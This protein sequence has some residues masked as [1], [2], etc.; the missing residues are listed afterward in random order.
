MVVGPQI[1]QPVGQYSRQDELDQQALRIMH[2]MSRDL[3][4]LITNIAISRKLTNSEATQLV[5]DSVRG[6]LQTNNDPTD[7]TLNMLPVNRDRENRPFDLLDYLELRKINDIKQAQIVALSRELLANDEKIEQYRATIEELEKTREDVGTLHANNRRVRGNEKAIRQSEDK[8]KRIEKE[9]NHTKAE[10][11][12]VTKTKDEEIVYLLKL[13]DDLEASVNKLKSQ[14][15]NDSDASFNLRRL[16]NLITP[17]GTDFETALTKLNAMLNSYQ[18]QD[19]I[20]KNLNDRIAIEQSSIQKHLSDLS[21]KDIQLRDF[22]NKLTTLNRDLTL[23]NDKNK[24]LENQLKQLKDDLTSNP[25]LSQLD[26]CRSELLTVEANLRKLTFDYQRKESELQAQMKHAEATKTNYEDISKQYNET[27][28]NHVQEIVK[29]QNQVASIEQEKQKI[30]NKLELLKSENTQLKN[31]AQKLDTATDLASSKR[32]LV[33]LQAER[34]SISN[35]HR[36]L[37]DNFNVLQLQLKKA[38]AEIDHN[39]RQYKF[40]TDKLNTKNEIS[41]AQI[42]RLQARIDELVK[43][44]NNLNKLNTEYTNAFKSVEFIIPR[45]NQDAIQRILAM[46]EKTKDN[47]RA[48]NTTQLQMLQTIKGLED[49]KMNV[50]GDRKTPETVIINQFIEQLQR[51]LNETDNDFK[52][53]T[54]DFENHRKTYEQMVNKNIDQ[55]SNDEMINFYYEVQILC[56]TSEKLDRQANNNTLLL[57]TTNSVVNNLCFGDK[58]LSNDYQDLEVKLEDAKTKIKILEEDNAKKLEALNNQNKLLTNSCDNT[59]A[60]L[61][62]E[63]I[64]SKNAEEQIRNKMKEVIKAV[65]NHVN[66]QSPEWVSNLKASLDAY[67][68]LKKLK[69]YVQK[70]LDY[71]ADPLIKQL[72]NNFLNQ[73]PAG[74]TRSASELNTRYKAQQK[75]ISSKTTTQSKTLI[76]PPTLKLQQTTQKTAQPTTQEIAQPILQPTTQEIAQ[77]ILQ[78]TAQ[79]AIQPI[80]QTMP[81]PITPSISQPITQQVLQQTKQNETKSGTTVRDKLMSAKPRVTENILIPKTKRKRQALKAKYRELFGSSDDEETTPTSKRTKLEEMLIDRDE[82]RT[83]TELYKLDLDASLTTLSEYDPKSPE[84]KNYESNKASRNIYLTKYFI[85]LYNYWIKKHKDYEWVE[86]YDGFKTTVINKCIDVIN[87]MYKEKDTLSN[88]DMYLRGTIQDMKTRIKELDPVN[89]KR[90]ITELEVVSQLLE[91]YRYAIHVFKRKYPRITFGVI[92]PQAIPSRDGSIKLKTSLFNNM[93]TS[94]EF[95]LSD[96]DSDIDIPKNTVDPKSIAE[97]MKL[98]HI[99]EHVENILKKRKHTRVKV[100]AA[101]LPELVTVQQ[102]SSVDKSN[103]TEMAET[104]TNVSMQPLN[105]DRQVDDQQTASSQNEDV[106][107]FEE[108]TRKFIGDDDNNDDDDED[109]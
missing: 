106:M 79:E 71:I 28:Q 75:Q 60:S 98:E 100:P 37:Q 16:I 51:N 104:H 32:E 97:K 5:I 42:K 9:L 61:Q 63:L 87:E 107:M 77:P 74:I 73:Y 47:M 11:D 6:A 29:L 43:E 54:G 99:A 50:F 83:Q 81:Q 109:L 56:K 66:V 38:N 26:S 58:C 49:H 41:E 24:L 101:Q 12:K 40:E 62:E 27:I 3:P 30:A 21:A 35:E 1:V 91:I 92:L 94:S 72:L 39:L 45:D 93:S 10:L 53:I 52:T 46:L 17:N 67:T 36:K 7:Y 23:T 105:V 44:S 48:A 80:S 95:V 78:P 8:I 90:Q 33:E 59:L 15:N 86:Q 82:T 55:I 102:D 70:S 31:N 85:Q 64:K 68:E 18:S 96:Y 65:S 103:D 34:D 25:T 69:K 19:A 13:N 22:E 89:Y 88:G 20:I 108:D 76:Q 2:Q 14:L 57:S 4:E 84:I